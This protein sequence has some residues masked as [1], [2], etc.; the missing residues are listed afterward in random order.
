MLTFAYLDPESIPGSISPPP[1][2]L[3]S[4]M[5]PLTDSHE[6]DNLLN[7]ERYAISDI[8]PTPPLPPTDPLDLSPPPLRYPETVGDLI[9]IRPSSLGGLGVFALRN[10]PA[11]TIILS[12]KPLVVLVDDGTRVDP[13]IASVNALS[14]A[15][16]KAFYNLSSYSSGPSESRL[17]SIVYSNGFTIGMGSGVFETASRINHSCVENTKYVWK[18]SIGRMVY[19]NKFRLDKGEEVTVSY[20]HNKKWLKI[21]YGFDCTC[22]QCTIQ[23]ERE[24]RGDNLAPEL[25][26]MT[27]GSSVEDGANGKIM[28]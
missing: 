18:K 5:T 28:E 11:G 12:E 6:L 27:I 14:P 15:R 25:E 19:Y 20:G 9:E 7:G 26:S 21:I 3:G 16:M 22:P 13:L 10:I 24:A 17:R 2:S 8:P 23:A 4:P 1:L